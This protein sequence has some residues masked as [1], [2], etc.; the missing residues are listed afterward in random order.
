LTLQL[1]AIYARLNSSCE[2]LFV[3]PQDFILKSMARVRIRVE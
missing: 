3:D 2:V 1:L